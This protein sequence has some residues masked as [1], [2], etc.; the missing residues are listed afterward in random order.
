MTK[1]PKE[2]WSFDRINPRVIGPI[3]IISVVNDNYVGILNESSYSIRRNSACLTREEAA[4]ECKEFF[5]RSIK[6]SIEITRKNIR[7]LKAFCKKE[8]V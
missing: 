2:M 8:G 4:K 3:P 7:A 6:D 5:D 1:H